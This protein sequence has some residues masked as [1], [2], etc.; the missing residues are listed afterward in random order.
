VI[1]HSQLLWLDWGLPRR[2]PIVIACLAQRAPCLPSRICTIPSRT[3]SPAC[4]LGVSC[5]RLV[6][7]SR[8]GLNL[9]IGPEPR[10]E[11]D[12][13]HVRS[14][15]F[16]EPGCSACPN[17][18][19]LQCGRHHIGNGVGIS[20]PTTSGPGA[21]GFGAGFGSPSAGS[22]SGSGSFGGGSGGFRFIG[23]GSPLGIFPIV[24]FAVMM[25]VDQVFEV[26]LEFLFV[27]GKKFP[28]PCRI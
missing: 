13:A 19:H 10:A 8:C 5:L 14:I 23:R 9:E 1:C 3:Y 22:G 6:G 20:G 2:S 16:I 17:R 28:A 12:A 24:L 4:V 11:V 26:F 18:P 27:H 25:P 15:V 21:M 7:V